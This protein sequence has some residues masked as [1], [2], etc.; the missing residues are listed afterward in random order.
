MWTVGGVRAVLRRHFRLTVGV[1]AVLVAAVVT[2]L[3]LFVFADDPAPA[4][5]ADISSN[6]KVCVL[7]TG[8]GERDAKTVWNGVQSATKKAP[9]NAQKLAVPAGSAVD[10]VPYLNSLVQLRCQFVITRGVELA[11]A[12]TAVATN[13]PD[14]SFLH[15]GDPVDLPNVRTVQAAAVTPAL[16]RDVVL[17]AQRASTTN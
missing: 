6:F 5:K 10:P 2:M 8:P 11:E 1:A 7:D 9:I 14:T 15:I 13:N 17:A 16:I 3:V 12:L 4:A